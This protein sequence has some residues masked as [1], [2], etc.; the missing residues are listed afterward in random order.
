[1]AYGNLFVKRSHGD[2]L[3]QKLRLLSNLANKLHLEDKAFFYQSFI[4]EEVI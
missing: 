3:S 2:R 4:V 1:M